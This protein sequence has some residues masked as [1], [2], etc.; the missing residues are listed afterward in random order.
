MVEALVFEKALVIGLFEVFV[1]V[2]DFAAWP[3]Q[4]LFA[5]GH[6]LFRL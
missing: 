3:R 5:I 4:K 2:G 1:G 6:K